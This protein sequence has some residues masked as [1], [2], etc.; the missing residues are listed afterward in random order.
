MAFCEYCGRQLAEG[1]I[2]TC[3]QN[4]AGNEPAEQKPKK[5]KTGLVIAIIV[6]I[7]I[8]AGG[9]TAFLNIANGYRKPLDSIASAIN[10]K[11]TDIDSLASI[12]LPDFAAA[13]YKKAVKIMKTSENFADGYDEL[14]QELADWYDSMD[15]EYGAGWKVKFDCSDKERL[16]AEQLDRVSAVYAGFYDSY[17]ESIC[18][19]IAD[20][21]KYDYED[22][23]DTMGLTASKAKDI[24]KV[25][26]NLMKEFKDIKAADGYNLI[27]RVVVSDSKGE[28]L[29]KSDKMTVKVIKLNGDWM[30]DYTSVISESGL[31]A[32]GM[33]LLDGIY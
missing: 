18:E 3:R 25:A 6:L 30:I 31:G 2:C 13:S 21:D 8:V 16:D 17:F 12:V 33:D 11:N 10:K 20:Y 26:V 4:Q 14:T 5:S 1:E 29:W 9:V 32:W 22:L 7:L 19:D 27:G 28:T 23:A 24:C 15:D